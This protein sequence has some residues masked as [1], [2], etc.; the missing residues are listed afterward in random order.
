MQHMES[1]EKEMPTIGSWYKRIQ[2]KSKRK[3]KSRL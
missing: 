2:A 3:Y 1:A